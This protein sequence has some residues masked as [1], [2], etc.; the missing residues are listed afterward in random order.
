MLSMRSEM[1]TKEG[2]DILD[3]MKLPE[4]RECHLNQ[5]S[6][7]LVKEQS[8]RYPGF[9]TLI[10]HDF[11]K[12]E[13]YPCMFEGMTCHDIAS[14]DICGPMDLLTQACEKGWITDA[15]SKFKNPNAPAREPVGP[16]QCDTTQHPEG[17]EESLEYKF[18]H[19]GKCAG[20]VSTVFNDCPDVG[21][22]LGAA[23][24]LAAIISFLISMVVVAPLTLYWQYRNGGANNPTVLAEGMVDL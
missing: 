18:A 10:A 4:D 6:H 24:G 7:A 11:A 5:I 22:T 16:Y 2:L 14:M 1:F 19:F 20:L 3:A 9:P 23:E 8:D 13:W 17:A 15:T 21:T 12:A